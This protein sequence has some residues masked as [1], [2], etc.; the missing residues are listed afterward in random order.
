MIDYFYGKFDDCSL[1]RF[2]F[3]VRTDRQRESHRD[4]DDHYTY[5]TSVGVSKN[6]CM[7]MTNTIRWSF[8]CDLRAVYKCLVSLF[9]GI[10]IDINL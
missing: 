9:C 10:A 2:G 7:T 8:C 6:I 3:I 1:S 4:A 5:A